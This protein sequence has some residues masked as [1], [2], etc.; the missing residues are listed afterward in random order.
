MSIGIA[1]ML[2]LGG[3][4]AAEDGP[5]GAVEAL[6]SEVEF[7]EDEGLEGSVS[8]DSLTW[9]PFFPEPGFGG[10]AEF[11]GIFVAVFRNVGAATVWVRYDLRFFDQEEFLIDAFI[12]IGQPVV[13]SVGETRRV[14]G[15]FLIRTDDPRDF[16][17]LALMRL[18]ARIRRPEE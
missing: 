1:L 8:I 16:E 17:R 18:V 15:D 7:V 3:C 12:P 2:L 11:E 13:L 5:S 9:L 14:E 6:R 4:F 10:T